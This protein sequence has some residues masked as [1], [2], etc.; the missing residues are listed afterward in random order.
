VCIGI[1]DDDCIGIDPEITDV[2]LHQTAVPEPGN[3]PFAFAVSHVT[4][5]RLR[6]G[7]TV[8]LA[9]CPVCFN[10]YAEK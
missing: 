3:D 4:T 6:I 10:S 7:F 2:A 9:Q 1:V 8:R 5:S